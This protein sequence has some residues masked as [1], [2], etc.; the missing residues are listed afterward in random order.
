[1]DAIR[2]KG[3]RA[4]AIV[5]VP[6]LAERFGKSKR[7]ASARIRK[8]QHLKDGPRDVYTTEAWLA[9]W[10]AKKS[11]PAMQWPAKNTSYDPWESLVVPR[12]IEIVGRLADEGKIRVIRDEPKPDY[13]PAA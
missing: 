2:Q 5:T 12:V 11:I 1:M 10:L 6:D 13:D 7:W 3:P 4:I 8:M 9:E